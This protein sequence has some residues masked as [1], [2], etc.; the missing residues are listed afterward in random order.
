MFQS[1]LAD[2]CSEA[3]KEKIKKIKKKLKYIGMSPIY[4]SDDKCGTEFARRKRNYRK[5]RI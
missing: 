2:G 4:I 3:K 5:K 1:S